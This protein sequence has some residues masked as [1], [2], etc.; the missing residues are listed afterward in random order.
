MKDN[1]KHELPPNWAAVVA[2]F[3]VVAEQ[4]DRVVFTYAPYIYVPG[5]QELP[6]DLYV[7]ESIHLKQQGDAPEVWWDRY[8]ADADFRLEQELEAYGAQLAMFN[9]AGNRRFEYEKN[10]LATDVSS[11]LYGNMVSYGDAVSQIRRIAKAITPAY[12]G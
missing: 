5:G 9:N 3:P 7:H 4:Q 12:E 10:R 11:A 1:I 8:L 6:P 2:K